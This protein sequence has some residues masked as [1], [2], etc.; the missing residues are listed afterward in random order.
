MC[1]LIHY[2]HVFKYLYY[3]YIISLIVFCLTYAGLCG[4]GPA[5]GLE[6]RRGSH[7]YE[8]NAWLWNFG[9]PQPRVAGL[10]VAKTVRIRKRCRAD[11]AKSG[12]ETR[13]ASKRAATK[14]DADI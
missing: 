11:A 6:M 8:V 1:L 14:N 12:W 5:K 9:R 10:S 13:R 2:L 3:T 7:V 4:H